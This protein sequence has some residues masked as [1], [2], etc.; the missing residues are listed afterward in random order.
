MR[1][2]TPKQLH[3]LAERYRPAARPTTKETADNLAA[4]WWKAQFLYDLATGAV[5]LVVV[6]LTLAAAFGIFYYITHREPPH[7][8]QPAPRPVYRNK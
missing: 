6:T 5:R 4:A 8:Y 1:P 3:E 2:L 7:N